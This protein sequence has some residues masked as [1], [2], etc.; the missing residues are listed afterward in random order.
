MAHY[1]IY[2]ATVMNTADPLMKGRMQVA[3]PALTGLAST[4]A[5]PCRDYKSI[6]MPPIGSPVWVMFEQGNADRPVWIGCAN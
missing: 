3:L 1:G 5:V 2:A 6:S 4:W